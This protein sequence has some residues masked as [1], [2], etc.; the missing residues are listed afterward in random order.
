[1]APYD[2]KADR[3]VR[4]CASC[5]QRRE[6]HHLL[7]FT[8]DEGDGVRVDIERKMFGRGL[9]LCL[10]PDC[11]HDALRKRLFR[12]SLGVT[13]S[14]DPGA[15]QSRIAKAA[16]AALDRRLRDARRGDGVRPVA[17]GEERP[18]AYRVLAERLRAD[19]H[20]ED[21]ISLATDHTE[22]ASGLSRFAS[23]V[24]RFTFDLPGA[25]T[26]R[27]DPPQ[28]AKGPVAASTRVSG[29]I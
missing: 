24:N 25:K 3:P 10:S 5:R 29:E 8:A 2:P 28:R 15:L 1:V 20:A 6:P 13:S 21:L 14:L 17:P 18:E 22:I 23:L 26:R 19:E 7:R 9:N 12:R 11:L 4:R 16:R 27:P